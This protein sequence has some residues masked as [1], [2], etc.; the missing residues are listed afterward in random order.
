MTKDDSRRYSR[1]IMLDGIGREGQE[2]LSRASVL[3]VGC[4]ALGTVAGLYLAGSGVGRIGLVDFD[5]IDLSNLQ[6]QLA[7]NINDIGLKKCETLASRI[8]AVNPSVNTDCHGCFLTGNKAHGLLEGYDIIVEGSD[9]PETKY[10]ISSVC[11][12]LKKPCVTG[13]VSQWNGQVLT[14]MPGH[15]TYSDFFPDA[16]MSGSFTPCALGGVLGPLPGIIGSIQA[17]EVIKIICGAGVPLAD[18]MLLVDSRSMK[19]HTVQI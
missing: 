8:K 11:H 18:R 6:R 14:F 4:G 19:F 15:A 17:A 9:N 12:E 2:K 16:S 3:L 5:T 1:N 7:F 10:L 13:G